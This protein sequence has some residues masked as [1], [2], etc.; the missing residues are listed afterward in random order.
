[1]S[2]VIPASTFI[3]TI[4]AL[5]LSLLTNLI[6]RRFV[7]LQK[8]RRMKAEISQH[9]KELRE[10][11]KNKDKAKE[12]K[13]RKKD[14]Q[15]RQMQA[16]VSTSRLKVTGI[17]FIPLLAVYYF[18]ANLL[19]GFN[20]TVAYSPVPIPYIISEFSAAGGP[21]SLFWWYFLSSFTFSG[22]MTKLLGTST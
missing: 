1:M 17:T 15:M 19:G 18:M 7:D 14:L 3:V 11:V 20:V 16:R 12:D 8:E 5:G 4:T 13:L 2:Y 22:L 9:N 21:V 10:A 6:T